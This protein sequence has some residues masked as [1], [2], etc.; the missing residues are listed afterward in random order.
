MRFKNKQHFFNPLMHLDFFLFNQKMKNIED[1][2][3]YLPNVIER[4]KHIMPA[5]AQCI[6]HIENTTK[7]KVYLL[8]PVDHKVVSSEQAKC[9]KNSYLCDVQAVKNKKQYDAGKHEPIPIL[10]MDHQLCWMDIL[11]KID[12]DSSIIVR[13]KLMMANHR[14]SAIQEVTKSIA[15]QVAWISTMTLKVYTIIGWHKD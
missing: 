8:F 1:Q 7:M 12:E 5:V 9:H 13:Y 10:D 2:Q 11:D 4:V 6:N 15:F 3:A 14:Q